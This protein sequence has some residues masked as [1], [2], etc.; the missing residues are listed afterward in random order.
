MLT[1][2]RRHPSSLW[3]TFTHQWRPQTSGEKTR[4]AGT[5]W[6]YHY[7][8]ANHYDST[9]LWRDSRYVIIL[10]AST[11]SFCGANQTLFVCFVDISQSTNQYTILP[12]GKPVFIFR[13]TGDAADLICEALKEAREFAKQR[14]NNPKAKAKRPFEVLHL[15]LTLTLI[16]TPF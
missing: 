11:K 14:Q 12:G 6:L 5:N 4:S 7:Q 13:H 9:I 1:D 2:D 10:L 16:L 15:T 3:D 8:W